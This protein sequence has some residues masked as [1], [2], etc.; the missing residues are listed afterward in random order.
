MVENG[1]IDFAFSFDSLV[2]ADLDVVQDDVEALGRKLAPTGIGFSHHSNIGAYLEILHSRL[3]ILVTP[4]VNHQWRGEDVTAA[5]FR[6]ACTRAGLRC[7]SQEI[8][9]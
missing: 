5:A 9:S 8:V 4:P 6:A 7:V 1:S 2:H 3:I